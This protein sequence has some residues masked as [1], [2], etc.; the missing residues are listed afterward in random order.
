MKSEFENNFKEK[1]MEYLIDVFVELQKDF[2]NLNKSNIFSLNNEQTQMLRMRYGLYNDGN[3]QT[4]EILG[5]NRN[6]TR[7]SAKQKINRILKKICHE[8]LKKIKIRVIKEQENRISL[9]IEY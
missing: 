6:K 2:Y 4:F 8:I 9:P 5:N 3:I 7:Q 1:E